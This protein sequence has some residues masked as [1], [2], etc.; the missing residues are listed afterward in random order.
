VP[1]LD[2]PPRFWGSA[3][4]T[5]EVDGRVL[6]LVH[7]DYQNGLRGVSSLGGLD[8]A[9]FV[10]PRAMSTGHGMGMDR[11]LMPLDVAFFDPAGLFVSRH[12]MALCDAGACPG[13]YPDGDWQ[14]AIEAPAG[15]LSWIDEGSVLRRAAAT[16][17]GR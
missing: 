2:I 5:V 6:R 14:L 11:V 9:L 13:Y 15:E 12:T 8:G 16:A 3:I 4:E 17:S 10:L 1:R 7:V